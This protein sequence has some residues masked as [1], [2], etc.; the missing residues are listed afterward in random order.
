MNLSEVFEATKDTETHRICGTCNESKPFKD[1]YRDGKDSNGNIRYRRDCKDCYKRA[2]LM[3]QALKNKKKK[4]GL[5][6]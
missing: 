5:K 2:R 3:E 1:F 6:R 4:G